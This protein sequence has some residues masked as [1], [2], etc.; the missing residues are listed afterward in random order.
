MAS[1]KKNN[2]EQTF[3]VYPYLGGYQHFMKGGGALP[4]FEENGQVNVSDI[5]KHIRPTNRY[6]YDRTF[7]GVSEE[8][9]NNVG[10]EGDRDKYN[11]LGGLGP[12]GLMANLFKGAGDLV[13]D[14]KGAFSKENYA[15]GG[16][17]SKFDESGGLRYG[18]VK[19]TNTTDQNALL[20]G[21]NFSK[22]LGMSNK[23]RKKLTESGDLRNTDLWWSTDDLQYGKYNWMD[24]NEDGTAK[25]D[26]I[27]YQVAKKRSEH[28][29][30]PDEGTC[31]KP[32]F[33]NGADCEAGG[34]QWTGDK[35]FSIKQKN[36]DGT[37]TYFNE[38]GS[39]NAAKSGQTQ[40]DIIEENKG[41]GGLGDVNAETMIF[42][43]DQEG[44]N[45][46]AG[47]TSYDE[48]TS[49]TSTCSDGT[50]LTEEDC[51]ANGGTWEVSDPT[52][53]IALTPNEYDPESDYGP[54]TTT[55]T[56]TQSEQDRINKAAESET[57]TTE[58]PIVEEESEQDKLNRKAEEEGARYGR[59]LR[60]MYIGSEILS[61]STGSMDGGDSSAKSFE[62]NFHQFDIDQAIVSDLDL[63][64]KYDGYQMKYGGSLQKFVNGGAPDEEETVDQK[65]KRLYEESKVELPTYL[66][67]EK[68]HDYDQMTKNFVPPTNDLYSFAPTNEPIDLQAEPES[69]WEEPNNVD[70]FKNWFKGDSHLNKD[71][72][73]DLSGND[74]MMASI[75]EKNE[76]FDANNPRTLDPA[77]RTD[78]EGA[79]PEGSDNL[80]VD[81]NYGD[82]P[83]QNAWNKGREILQTGPI[84][85]AG[86]IYGKTSEF[87]V[88]KVVPFLEDTYN[89]NV[90]K[91]NEM[92][93]RSVSAEDVV[94]VM[95]E[96][97]GTGSKGYHD[98]NKGGYGDSL[99]GTGKVFGQ[100][101]QGQELMEEQSD[102]SGVTN[103][104]EPSFDGL[105][106]KDEY[107]SAQKTYLGEMKNG[108]ELPKAQ[109]GLEKVYKGGKWVWN[110]VKFIWQATKPVNPLRFNLLDNVFLS[111]GYVPQISSIDFTKTPVSGSIV[112]DSENV[113]FL[114]INN[115]KN[116]PS[117]VEM[118]SVLEKYRGTGIGTHLYNEGIKA[119]ASNK[120]PGLISGETLDNPEAT[121]SIWKHFNSKIQN[122]KGEWV[123]NPNPST[124][125]ST[126]I[127][128]KKVEYSGS[129]IKLMGTNLSGDSKIAETQKFYNELGIEESSIF[130]T[131]ITHTAGQYNFNSPL[132]RGIRSGFNQK[133][134]HIGNGEKP[135]TEYNK[136]PLL[137]IPTAIGL[138]AYTYAARQNNL[139][140]E[141]EA[142]YK[143][144]Q[145][146]KRANDAGF[147]TT[148]EY[149][150]HIQN[151]GPQTKEDNDILLKYKDSLDEGIYKKGGQLNKYLAG[152]NTGQTATLCDAYDR[153]VGPTNPA[154]SKADYSVE[155][156]DAT[157]DGGGA[158]CAIPGT[159][160]GMKY[161]G[162]LPKFQLKGGLEFDEN[163]NVVKTKVLDLENESNKERKKR[164]KNYKHPHLQ[165]YY[166]EFANSGIS[167]EKTVRDIMSSMNVGASDTLFTTKGY[168]A[169]SIRSINNMNANQYIGSQ[170]Y[171]D[172][173]GNW[174]GNVN[175]NDK[176]DYYTTEQ[177]E[178][179]LSW[180]F[181]TSLYRND[182]GTKTG[183]L[184][185]RKK[186]GGDL[187]TFQDKGE[188]KSNWNLS[189]YFKG[190]QGFI[191]DFKGES[192]KKTVSENPTVNKVLDNT[193]TALTVGGM[194]D[195]L[196]PAASIMDGVNAG[197]SGARA[198]AA[199]KGS[200]QR[201]KH[202]ENMALNATSMI[203]GF[204]LASGSAS[205]TKDAAT[206]A[207]VLDDQSVTKTVTDSTKA[208]NFAENMN[209]EKS[210]KTTAKFGGEQ[211]AEIDMDLYYELMQA[212]ADIKIIR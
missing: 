169:N 68:D 91:Q 26:G 75:T 121:V 139:D 78:M 80:G 179:G 171:D 54:H 192:T 142:A 87:V 52:T 167:N 111:T 46:L 17:Y 183:V 207:G 15:P 66:Q 161:G 174:Q 131:D 158:E 203:P 168:D 16:K 170:M 189:G 19:L 32:E 164:I 125:L 190:E 113:G 41:T 151:V 177:D 143:K 22:Y 107:L 29:R 165:Q 211:F 202:T 89:R 97:A 5:A 86:D 140:A 118:I 197:I 149:M 9:K 11:S 28:Y 27:N 84:G 50:S 212:G 62:T 116:S 134:L 58:G 3:N 44:D 56:E 10:F 108:A 14:V 185:S 186:F 154:N 43:Y 39:V 195:Y 83:I 126:N 31:S 71:P 33:T 175:Y 85:A 122:K 123:D 103:F 163:G 55:T 150:N 102:L 53:D 205:L 119:T 96:T 6:K 101:Q 141:H 20:H 34:G 115:P 1:K 82:G 162:A 178:D 63:P 36:K 61:P 210:P 42:D 145:L 59:E 148:E 12:M 144:K 136:L 191:P 109:G 37:F 93:K 135:F 57:T 114:N 79:A 173:T 155:K 196:G 70:K 49:T 152:G 147:N 124:G 21:E 110:G 18:N 40:Y 7:N 67:G 106:Y 100:V 38:D 200:D 30:N 194:Q 130:N 74:E 128:T 45:K 94:P 198:Y 193:Q 187:Q 160:P 13:G 181:L 199:P 90:N 188:N 23:E 159:C 76:A 137:T 77:N 81:V 51:R 206:Y 201:Q 47:F 92:Y 65:E 117:S 172:G 99:Y 120:Y 72:G 8:W 208:S 112:G 176:Q 48:T 24:K 129:P 146:L 127:D 105:K 88:D 2:K 73:P 4:K 69:T 209:T 166:D 60:K 104:M 35:L 156:A 157:V 95:E 153:P 138:G 184:K 204:G 132:W 180:D 133:N 25:F 182:E 98:I 64:K